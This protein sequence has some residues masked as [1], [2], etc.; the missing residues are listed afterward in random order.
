MMY[1]AVGVAVVGGA[2]LDAIGMAG[3]VARSV[4]GGQR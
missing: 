1:G 3:S 2:L 4:F